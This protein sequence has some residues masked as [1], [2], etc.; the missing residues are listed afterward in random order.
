MRWEKK[1]IGVVQVREWGQ[2]LLNAV[3]NLRFHKIREIFSMVA[4]LLAFRELPSSA[5]L[6]SC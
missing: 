1:W 3:S 4:D 5:E 2:A 6:D